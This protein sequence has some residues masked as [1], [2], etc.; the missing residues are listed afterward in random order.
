ML[1][2]RENRDSLIKRAIESIVESEVIEFEYE[3]SEI[4]TA[5]F[6]SNNK[7]NDS[8]ANLSKRNISDRFKRRK[9]KELQESKETSFFPNSSSYIKKQEIKGDVD[10]Q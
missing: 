6:E 2:L 7:A 4:I 8:H 10:D 1:N 9:L 5:L 3:P